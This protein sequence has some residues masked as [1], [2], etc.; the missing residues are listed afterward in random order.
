M[1]FAFTKISIALTAIKSANIL[2]KILSQSTL[3]LLFLYVKLVITLL[4]L[5]LA[6]LMIFVKLAAI[7]VIYIWDG[8]LCKFGITFYIFQQNV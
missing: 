5:I 6:M 7:D 3:N 1:E 4:T 2:W 8:T